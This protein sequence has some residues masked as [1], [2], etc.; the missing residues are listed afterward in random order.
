MP[1]DE[2]VPPAVRSALDALTEDTQLSAAHCGFTGVT[3]EPCLLCA[4]EHAKLEQ[5]LVTALCAWQRAQDVK[6]LKEATE[7]DGVR[8]ALYAHANESRRIGREADILSLGS[9]AVLA[10]D[11][12]Q[13][14]A[15]AFA[16]H[17]EAL[18]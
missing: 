7:D 10:L 4:E 9:A 3:N 5:A 6:A 1:K 18:K 2:I 14:L 11:N 15:D 17:L 16:A 12:D 13:R 8:E